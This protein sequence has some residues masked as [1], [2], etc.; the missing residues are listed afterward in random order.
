VVGAYNK[1]A[2]AAGS[3]NVVLRLKATT[4]KIDAEDMQ[5]IAESEPFTHLPW[6]VNSHVS[7]ELADRIQKIMIGLKDS[8]EGRLVLKSAKVTNFYA[9]SDK[10][11][12]KV[13]E[14]TKYA[15]GEEY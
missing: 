12:D 13:R 2:G 4:K 10:D 9:V 11:F 15:L 14:I 6:A 7:V 1:G 5:I 8:E 3:G